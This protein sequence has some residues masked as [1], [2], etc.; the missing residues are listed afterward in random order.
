MNET[1]DHEQVAAIEGDRIEQSDEKDDGQYEL[2]FDEYLQQ[3]I[4]AQEEAGSD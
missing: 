2:N 4:Q 3:M 1:V